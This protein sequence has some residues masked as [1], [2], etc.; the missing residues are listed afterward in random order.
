MRVM[1][2][3]TGAGR[4]ALTVEM[5]WSQVGAGPW[6]HSAW[7]AGGPHAEKLQ[8][9]EWGRVSLLLYRGRKWANTPGD[10][11]VCEVSNFDAP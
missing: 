6:R 5:H 11:G 7:V 1:V 3:S 9:L 2:G 4:N 10:P 8:L